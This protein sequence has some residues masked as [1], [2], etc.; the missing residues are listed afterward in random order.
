MVGEDCSVVEH[1]TLERK[2]CFTSG[3]L[4]NKLP[5]DNHIHFFF[6]FFFAI[7]KYQK[8][9]V[10]QSTI[11]YTNF[12]SFFFFRFGKEKSKEIVKLQSA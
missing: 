8:V 11:S 9:I 3:R 12:F 1:V 10:A 7:P 2:L 4:I 5:K 6:F